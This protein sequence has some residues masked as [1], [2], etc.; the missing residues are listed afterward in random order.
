[1]RLSFTSEMGK[2]VG[3]AG[4]LEKLPEYAQRVFNSNFRDL[5]NK[6]GK[7]P[8]VAEVEAGLKATWYLPVEMLRRFQAE[9]NRNLEKAAHAKARA[10]C[11]MRR[12]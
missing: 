2:I 1:M 8:E 3:R 11:V 10:E 7:A 9:A 5:I 4:R 12:R 6:Q